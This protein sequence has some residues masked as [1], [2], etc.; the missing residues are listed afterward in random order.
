MLDTRNYLTVTEGQFLEAV[1]ASPS[2]F[3]AYLS[4]SPDAR[5]ALR[6]QIACTYADHKFYSDL[7]K[8]T[9]RFFEQFVSSSVVGERDIRS[10]FEIYPQPSNG[11]MTIRFE[12]DEPAQVSI[13]LMDLLGREVD[14]IEAGSYEPGRYSIVWS[15]R[16]QDG[17]YLT[18][19]EN[20]GRIKESRIT[21]ERER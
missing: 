21:V 3:P 8:T 11:R 18:L 14:I 12:L 10:S 1:L 2:S 9:L 7:N 5:S 19:F 17:I 6:E 20:N 16:L 4:M 13:R 15:N